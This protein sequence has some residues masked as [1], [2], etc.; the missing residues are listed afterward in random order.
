[1]IT[2][3]Q[4][5]LKPKSFLPRLQIG[6]GS[7]NQNNI[8]PYNSCRRFYRKNCLVFFGIVQLLYLVHSEYDF[9]PLLLN[10]K[11]NMCDFLNS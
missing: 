2:Q 4:V 11:T 1:M 8:K 9:I 6:C 7:K 10:K 5:L 3:M